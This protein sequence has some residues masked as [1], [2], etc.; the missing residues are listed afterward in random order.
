MGT[1]NPEL[2]NDPFYIGLRQKRVTGQI[3][4]EFVDE[5]MKAVQKKFGKNCLIQFEDF[6]NEDVILNFYI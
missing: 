4:Y 3:Y 2:I 1:N 5:F 6:G